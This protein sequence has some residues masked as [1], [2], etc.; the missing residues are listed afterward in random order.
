MSRSGIV[1]ANKP[2]LRQ[3]F[4]DTA[5]IALVHISI[6]DNL[7]CKDARMTA[8]GGKG[9]DFCK[10]IPV[11]FKF[12]AVCRQ[13]ML[14]GSDHAFDRLVVHCLTPCRIFFIIRQRVAKS[15]GD[16]KKK[17]CPPLRGFAPGICLPFFLV[18]GSISCIL[19]AIHKNGFRR[20]GAGHWPRI[21]T[22]LLEGIQA[23]IERG[24]AE[25]EQSHSE[26]ELL[27][28]VH[29]TASISLAEVCSRLH[30]GDVVL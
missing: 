11:F 5:Q 3:L 14:A 12:P 13:N 24:T 4:Y 15:N 19:K 26:T 10:G 1:D 9:N 18:S 7:A 21:A 25:K 29:G 22:S 2:I 20:T 28:V 30:I 17:P 16:C 23:Q 6:F 8:N 27:Y